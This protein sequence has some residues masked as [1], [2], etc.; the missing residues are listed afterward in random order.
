MPDLS[1]DEVLAGLPEETARILSLVGER[2]AREGVQIYL[3]GGPVRDLLLGRP[4][5]DVDL[6]VEGDA[7]ELADAVVGVPEWGPFEV[8]RHD[9][10]GTVRIEAAGAHVDLASLRHETYSRPG[11][12]PEV[13]AGDFGQDARRRDFSVNALYLPLDGLSPNRRQAILDPEGGL[14]DLAGRRLRILHPLSFHDDPTRAWR[15]AR[16]VARLGFKL[17]RGSRAA[18]RS[19]LRDGAF[20]G[21]SGERFRRE[22]Q[23]AVGE[24]EHGVHVGQVFGRLDEWHVLGALEPGLSL[25]RDRQGPLRRLSRAMTEPDWV[26]GRWLGWVATLAV[27]LAPLPAALRRR[28]LE[29]FAVRGEQAARIVALGRNADRTLK[30]LGRARGRGA[31]DSLL[32]D[33]PEETIQALYALA[34]APLRRRMLRWGAEDRRRRSPVGGA[35]LVELGLSG[36]EI[37]RV[38]SRIRTGFLDGEIANR[39]EGLALAEEMAR[40]AR[41]RGRGGRANSSASRKAAPKRS[42]KRAGRVARARGIADTPASV[43]EVDRPGPDTPQAPRT[44]TK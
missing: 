3:V 5:V 27:W 29:R 4:V 39:E 14:E 13:M 20:G 24:A 22:L 32:S 34:P 17:D 25:P 33:L 38:L 1:L 12:L 30:S 40:R 11:A 41:R 43:D 26:A 44:E 21:V 42:A 10:F 16:F 18:L 8:T 37:G 15:A 2:A 36:P 19:A 7:Q 23:L 6:V 28:A 9:R 31:V 35:D